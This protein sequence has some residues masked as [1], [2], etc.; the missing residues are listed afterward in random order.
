MS[1]CF[2]AFG[3]A[4]KIPMVGIET[5]LL[6]DWLYESLGN[7]R[8]M[9]TDSSVFL[10]FVDSA[11]FWDRFSN[12]VWS[13]FITETFN[14]HVQDQDKYVKKAFGNGY[15]SVRE[16]EKDLSL[17][18]MNYHPAVGGVRPYAPA[19]VPVGGLHIQEKGDPLS[20]ASL[21]KSY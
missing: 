3:R 13:K 21:E 18:L 5:T 15:P 10:K 2:L 14:Y 12:F 16:L 19:V 7:P 1:D 6:F 8:N 9:A 17:V 20:K 11:S 4:F